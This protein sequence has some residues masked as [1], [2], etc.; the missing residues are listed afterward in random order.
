MRHLLLEPL[1]D[2]LYPHRCRVCGDLVDSIKYGS[3]CSDCWAA[4]RIFDG[5]ETS[6]S[7]CGAISKDPRLIVKGV[8]GQCD[9]DF[10][11]K[12]FAIGVYEKALA[13]TVVHLKREPYLPAVAK[14]M[15]YRVVDQLSISRDHAIIPV[16]LSR[17]RRFER[18]HNQAEFIG[19]II[20]EY[21]GLPYY[22][23][24]IFRKEH[25]AMHRVGMDKKAREATVKNLFGVRTPRLVESRHVIL[26]DDVFTS[27]STASYC[28]KVLKKSGAASVT[29]ITLARAVLYR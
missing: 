18:G 19:E 8:C 25:T 2:T 27:G 17:K 12:A 16:P 21:A 28:A 29:V 9:E 15:L 22:P 11:D 3:A 20:A 7:K 4:T 13:A 1:L 5:S 26:V 10:Y 6:C 14:E 23:A 24:A